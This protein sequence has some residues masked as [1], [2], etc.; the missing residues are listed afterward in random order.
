MTELEKL[1]KL[2]QELIDTQKHIHFTFERHYHSFENAIIEQDEKKQEILEFFK[3]H[4]KGV[5]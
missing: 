2:L 4:T 1:E 5:F 3:T